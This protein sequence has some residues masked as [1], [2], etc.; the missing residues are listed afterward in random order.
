M[1]TK[2]QNPFSTTFSKKPKQTFIERTELNEIIDN[3]SFDDPSESVYKITGVRGSGKT[4]SLSIIEEE[5][6]SEFNEDQGWLVYGLNPTRNMLQQLASALNGEKFINSSSKSK[7]VSFSVSALG[8]GFGGGYSATKQDSLFDVGIELKHMIEIVQK[9]HKKILI[10]VD[11]VSKTTAMIE[12][13]HEFGTWL[14]MNFPVYLVCTGL[15]E[16]IIELGNV[17]NLT[18]FRRATTIQ[19]N[20]INR[21]RIVE[22]YKKSLSIESSEAQ[23]LSKITN[24]YA[25]ALQQ[26]GALYFKK[27]NKETMEDITE[28]LKTSL[29]SNVYEKIWEE[30][31]DNDRRILKLMTE[32]KSYKREEFQCVF[33][34]RLSAF[35]VYRDRLL[36]R[37]IINKSGHGYISHALPYMN[38]YIKEYCL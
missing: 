24:G 2:K 25:Y 23:A 3:L 11:D 37:G 10:T 5:Y 13:A 19:M 27:T 17:K 9:K 1:T 38:E 8:T 31:T 6:R 16:N 26:L 33:P 20:P 18:F 14:R 28:E 32:N 36:K 7:S 22:M 15:Y 4:V 21:V 29:F 35:S 12:F 34:E 30:L